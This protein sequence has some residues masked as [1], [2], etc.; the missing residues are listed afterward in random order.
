ME[1]L[2]RFVVIL[3]LLITIS[4]PLGFLLTSKRVLD[5]T[6]SRKGLNI[7]RHLITGVITGGGI[8]FAAI[9]GWGVHGA[10]IRLFFASVIALN[11]YSIYREV[12]YLRN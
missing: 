11:L 8:V 9:T 3:L 12:K 7:A 6:S 5:F 1:S 2:A 10:G 4:A